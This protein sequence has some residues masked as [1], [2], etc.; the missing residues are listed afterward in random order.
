MVDAMS[1]WY[2]LAKYEDINA[3]YPFDSNCQVGWSINSE[4]VITKTSL[5][6]R[7]DK[8]K[9]YFTSMVDVLDNAQRRINSDVDMDKLRDVLTFFKEFD[10]DDKEVKQN[11]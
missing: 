2:A 9:R 1:L 6:H 3:D 5:N 4:S 11:D 10:A 8:M 7:I